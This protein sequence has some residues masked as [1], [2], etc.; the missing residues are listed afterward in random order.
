MIEYKMTVANIITA[1]RILLVPIFLV[2][3]LTEMQNK[4][5]IAFVI[6]IVAS[7]TDAVDGYYAR[8]L[9]QITELG[10]FLDPHPQHAWGTR[11]CQ[12]SPR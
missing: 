3:L 7:V 6:F 2:I 11:R 10:K 8:K 5:I 12:F 1:G 9:N 4:E